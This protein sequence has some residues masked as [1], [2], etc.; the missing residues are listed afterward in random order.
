MCLYRTQTYN[1]IMQVCQ[2]RI[3][4][5]SFK[6]IFNIVLNKNILELNWCS[7]CAA[8]PQLKTPDFWGSNLCKTKKIVISLYFMNG[9]NQ[10]QKYGGSHQI[11]Y[12]AGTLTDPSAPTS[13]PYRDPP[14]HKL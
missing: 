8:G 14:I 2:Q 7:L 11:S 6:V 3:L 1:I 9:H 4:Q 12:P 5:K 10:V 13:D